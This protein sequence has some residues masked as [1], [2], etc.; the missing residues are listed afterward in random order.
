VGGGT[1][2]P[3][4]DTARI[5]SSTM[6]AGTQPRAV[7][8]RAAVAASTSACCRH[9]HRQAQAYIT[10]PVR[11]TTTAGQLRRHAGTTTH[12]VA[13]THVPAQPRIQLGCIIHVQGA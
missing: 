9:R 5:A 2:C 3:L 11:H 12:R 4:R 13:G 1:R 7:T 8:M 10:Q 6:R